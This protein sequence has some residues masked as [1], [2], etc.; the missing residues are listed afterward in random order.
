MRDSI[1]SLFL[2]TAVAASAFGLMGCSGTLV[3]EEPE[4]VLQSRDDGEPTGDGA[5]CSWEGTTMQV[6]TCGELPVPAGYGPYEVG[7]DFP[8]P[9]GCNECTCTDK[10]I[11]C[12]VLEC[13]GDD[14]S[15]SDSSGDRAA[16][17]PETCAVAC[18]KEAKVCP[19]GSTVGREGPNCEFA[20]CPDDVVCTDDAMECPDGT[21]V[22]RSGPDCEFVCETVACP[23][24]AKMCADGTYVSRQAPDCQFAP[25]AYEPCEN[26]ACGDTC[27]LCP[28]DDSDCVEDASLKYCSATGEC[29]S[30]ASL[31]R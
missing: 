15:D 16:P 11:M 21:W 10:G 29:G 2:V 23:A 8:S 14:G 26:K 7:E 24:D 4:K 3:D 22:G 17:E 5:T 20:A 12:T 13:D 19:D 6:S 27:T 30:E 18:T 25:C 9:D 31:C 1:H 28:P